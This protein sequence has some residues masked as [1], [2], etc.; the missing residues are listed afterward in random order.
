M[1]SSGSSSFRITAGAKVSSLL[2]QKIRR[3]RTEDDTT[4]CAFVY[5]VFWII[6]KLKLIMTHRS[7]ALQSA[8]F[9]SF[10]LLWQVGL[11][12]PAE[13]HWS[14]GEVRLSSNVL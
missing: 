2:V 5:P 12:Y 7:E 9:N 3:A 1:D 8:A 10:S 13:L 4:P 6:E 11:P 14:R